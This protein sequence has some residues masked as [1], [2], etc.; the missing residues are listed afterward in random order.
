VNCKFK[1]EWFELGNASD[2]EEIHKGWETTSERVCSRWVNDFKYFDK[3]NKPGDWGEEEEEEE[4]DPKCDI[5]ELPY[6]GTTFIL[7]GVRYCG[8]C[9]DNRLAN[10]KEQREREKNFEDEVYDDIEWID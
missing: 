5:C 4:E 2:S 7:N 8:K 9:Y 10:E 6:K 1:K 3:D